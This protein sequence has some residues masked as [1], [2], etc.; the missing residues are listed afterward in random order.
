MGDSTLI[1]QSAKM[2]YVL[3]GEFEPYA[4]THPVAFRNYDRAECLQRADESSC[5]IV[6]NPG[7]TACLQA[8]VG[9]H[10]NTGR[11]REVV[12]ADASQRSPRGDQASCQSGCGIHSVP[13]AHGSAF[14]YAKPL[15]AVMSQLFRKVF[16]RYSTSYQ[17][18]KGPVIARD[19]IFDPN[20]RFTH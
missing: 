17:Q 1:F 18:I 20:N 12:L 9:L 16:D 3:T 15:S 6:G 4:G 13:S 14:A 7:G 5:F 2:P 19:R 11:G 10:R 8:K